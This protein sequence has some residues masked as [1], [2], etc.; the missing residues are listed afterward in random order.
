LVK[1]RN[2]TLGVGCGLHN[3]AGVVLQDLNPAWEIAGMVGAWFNRQTK[4]GGKKGS[5]KFGNQFL[6]GVTFIAPFF[7]SE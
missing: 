4:I 6:A 2:G 7:A 5:A 1:I 3:G